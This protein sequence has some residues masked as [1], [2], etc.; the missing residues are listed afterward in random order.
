MRIAYVVLAPRKA[1]TSGN[2]SV[3]LL[4]RESMDTHE[5]HVLS[6][7]FLCKVGAAQTGL[8]STLM[9]WPHDRRVLSSALILPFSSWEELVK[10]GRPAITP[11]DLNLL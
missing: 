6:S 10:H 11:R 3:V 9:T 8:W 7:R 2:Q 5:V 4:R 1:W